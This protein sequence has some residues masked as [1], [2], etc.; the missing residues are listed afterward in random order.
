LRV[1]SGTGLTTVFSGIV[2]GSG[3]T[4]SAELDK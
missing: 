3:I 1:T 2:S 4:G